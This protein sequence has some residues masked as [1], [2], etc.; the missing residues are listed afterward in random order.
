MCKT[1]ISWFLL[2]L[3]TASTALADEQR[4]RFELTPFAAYGGGGEFEQTSLGSDLD[5][6]E[7]ASFGLIFNMRADANRQYEVLYSHQETELDTDGLFANEPVLDLD[8]D[9]LHVGG[10]YAFD[11]D[12]GKPYVVGT[13]GVSRFEPT[14]SGFD[15][16]TFLSLSFGGGVQLFPSKRLGLR[17]EGRVFGSFVDSKSKIFCRSGF[18]TNF[19]AVRVDGDALWQWQVIAGLVSRF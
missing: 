14:S 19:C 17:L 13:I 12:F 2:F 4:P 15:S 10:T 8:I 9:Y 6:D 16:E 11:G 3:L 5:V 18:D 7:A 1:L